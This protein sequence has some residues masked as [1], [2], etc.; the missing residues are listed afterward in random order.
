MASGTSTLETL[1]EREGVHNT[2]QKTPVA[3][4][5][6]KSVQLTPLKLYFKISPWQFN[7]VTTI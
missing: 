3:K 2:P 1:F 4:E 6:N 7:G 5:K